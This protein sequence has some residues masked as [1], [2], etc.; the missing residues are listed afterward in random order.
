M[1]DHVLNLTDETFESELA[2][3]TGPVLLDFWAPWCGPCR[4][5][6]PV[7]E[8]IAEEYAGRATVAKL[9]AEDAKKTFLKFGISN[10][11]SLVVLKDGAGAEVADQMIGVVP[12]DRLTAALEKHLN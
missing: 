6:A 4:Q 7:V 1:S 3:A 11:P 8:A 2:G 5:L 10:M 12:K 9:N